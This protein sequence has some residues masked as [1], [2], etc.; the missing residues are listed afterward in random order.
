MLSF[1][2]TSFLNTRDAL[3]LK[4]INELKSKYTNLIQFTPLQ[5]DNALN[6]LLSGQAINARG[7]LLRNNPIKSIL[8]INSPNINALFHPEI[9]F[10]L[11]KIAQEHQI[12]IKIHFTADPE[13]HLFG[14]I[15]AIESARIQVLVAL[16]QLAGLI[17]DTLN[18]IPYYLHNLLSGRKHVQLQS[19]MEETSTNIYLTSPFHDTCK[20]I[21][22]D[23]RASTIYISG[24]S[25]SSISRAK[26]LLIKLAAQK[27]K[28]MYHKDSIMDARKID[29][30][31]LNKR[32]ELRKIMKD[33][34]SYFIFPALGSGSN[35]LSIYAENRINVERSV[36]L[37]NY[38]T[39]SIYEAS[40]DFIKADSTESFIHRVFGSADKFGNI[41]C[42][43]SQTSGADVFFQFDSNKLEL[44]GTERQVRN[45]YQLLCDMRFFKENHQFTTFTLELATDQREFISGKKNGKINKIMKSCAVTIRFVIANE[46]NS[47][48]IVESNNYSKALDGLTMLQD[49]LPAET[50]F[51]V[52][53][54]YHRRI[55]GV[56]GKNIQKV[57]KK[58]GVYVKFSGAE[59][60]TSM[61]GY[62]ENE[63][64][65]VARTPMKNQINLENLKHSVTE[66][67]SFQKDK[68]Y[69]FTTMRIPYVLH[70][71]I[72]TLYGNQLRE[73]CR[74]N[75]AKIWWP[76]RLGSDQVIVYGPQSQIP[77]VISFINQFVTVEK[78]VAVSIPQ[79]Q[80]KLLDQDFISMLQQKIKCATN[81]ELNVQHLDQSQPSSTNLVEWVSCYDEDNVIIYQFI[82]KIGQ[83]REFIK[84]KELLES[85]IKSNELPFDHIEPN[86]INTSYTPQ[87]ESVGSSTSHTTNINSNL[88]SLI[89][90]PNPADQDDTNFNNYEAHISEGLA[91]LESMPSPPLSESHTFHL[92]DGITS[93]LLSAP[94]PTG[95]N[96]WASPSI[97]SNN[98][99]PPMMQMKNTHGGNYNSVPPSPPYQFNPTWMSQPSFNAANGT[100][101]HKSWPDIF[102]GGRDLFDTLPIRRASSTQ[103]AFEFIPNSTTSKIK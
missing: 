8:Y 62:F 56:A 72:P 98:V 13:I 68:E 65:V 38:L 1:C 17:V 75:N 40:F 63:D 71:I 91:T 26:E 35:S 6:I 92:H 60:F 31:L 95:K 18:E 84:A 37:L 54:I 64:N 66:F 39:S 41:I 61:G 10:A 22:N 85:F 9:K 19:I 81:V 5:Q 97:Q 12:E 76:E 77:A 20:L 88:L 4:L 2:L 74:T 46:Y 27:S 7:E 30:I 70:R 44:F 29:W 52:P 96:I 67:I 24:D 58:Y 89:F 48:I 59:E 100:T 34:G 82:H 87:P 21:D 90:S 16:D 94:Q 33:N 32:M 47:S 57:M 99:I 25:V 53:E 51:Y 79:K 50:S 28:S 69:T 15:G 86:T 55:I 11:T 103:H 42:Q 80:T 49:E 23:K 73:I 36:R 102:F 83:E 3:N 78:H 93:S 14:S 101:H 45:A 43:L